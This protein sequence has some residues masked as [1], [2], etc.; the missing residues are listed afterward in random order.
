MTTP[1]PVPPAVLG[2]PFDT[3]TAAANGAGEWSRW[4]GYRT[5]SVYTLTS[6]E[7][8][9]VRN[10]AA[11]FDI[12]PMIK[13]RIAGSDAVPFL[14]RLLTR[15]VGKI[16]VGRAAYALWCDDHGKVI[17]DGTLFRLEDGVFQ[18]NAQER[19]LP[20]LRDSAI[21]F[22]I[23]IADVTDT[24]AALAL[25]GP[26]SCAVLK[27]LGLAGIETLKPYR[28]ETFDFAGEP[29]VVSRTGYTGDLGYELW[30][31]PAKAEALWD[32][33]MEAG[34]LHGITP[35]GG[36]ALELARI[37][38]GFIQ[39]NVDFM[40]IDRALRPSRG[41]S[42]FEL[43]LGWLV[44]LE[45]GH[46][47]GRRALLAEREAGSRYRLVGLDVA[48]NKPAAHALIYRG[49]GG[50]EVG[51]VTSAAWSPTLKRNLALATLRAD[52][53]GDGSDLW[54]DI[55]VAKELK[56]EKI[57]AT[58]RILERPFFNPPRR[59]ATPPADR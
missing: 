15:N 34:A 45:K 37:E 40:S 1:A 31:A 50:R 5:A 56:W 44:D 52:R 13:Y 59:W 3:R 36:Q 51:S 42:P 46:F 38:A 24:I 16:A 9:A 58:C 26:T 14:D 27:A 48:H 17:D 49:R 2:T 57:R 25:Q 43:G 8:A 4:A 53:A 28:L 10:T 23:T 30:I 12:S 22:S 20:W 35:A 29:L 32:A 47:N 33:L 41:R 19:H 39:T 18:L 21:G 55:Y 54:A 11:L 7:H 6:L